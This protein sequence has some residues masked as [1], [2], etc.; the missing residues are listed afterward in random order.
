MHTAIRMASSY[1]SDIG[2]RP[3]NTP[4]GGGRRRRVK[5]GDSSM[6]TGKQARTGRRRPAARRFRCRLPRA[7]GHPG[8][9]CYFRR[10]GFGPDALRR[11][12]TAAS[13]IRPDLQLRPA[14]A[15]ALPTGTR[16]LPSIRPALI[17]PFVAQAG[18]DG[19][20]H[21]SLLGAGPMAWIV[22]AVLGTM[23]V[24]SWAIMISK[25]C[26]T[27]APTSTAR[28]SSTSSAAP[29][30]SARSMRAAGRLSGTPHGGPL[31]GRLRR[32][33]RPGQ[34]RPGGGPGGNAGTLPRQ[35]PRPASS[36]ACAAPSASSCGARPRHVLPRH[37]RLGAPFIGLF[38]TVWGIMVA[39]NDIGCPGRIAG[40]GR[41]RH[42]RGADQHRR[43]AG[44]RPS[45]RWWASTT[46]ARGCATCAARCRTSCWS[47]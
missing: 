47:S 12:P 46:S 45:R 38:G 7:R 43:R 42:R 25:G 17:E 36:A 31:P 4:D 40:R 24:G 32:D 27:A 14:N 2:V 9:P 44:A 16:S 1:D 11:Q 3:G 13:I 20:H 15:T 22:F 41:A 26:N 35:E 30:A 5:D 21:R 34:G 28:S 37:H 10:S 19:R 29:S 18:H 39:F 8:A 33:R 23:S 6:A